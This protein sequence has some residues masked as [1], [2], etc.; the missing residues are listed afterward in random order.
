MSA[1]ATPAARKLL[2]ALHGQTITTATGRQNTILALNDDHVL[3]GTKRSPNGTAISIAWVQDALDRL[4]TDGEVEINVASV[5]HRSA[6]VGAVLLTLPGASIAATSPPRIRL[7]SGTARQQTIEIEGLNHWWHDL[8]DERYWLE[9]TD[10][11]D[12][13]VDLHAPQRDA[14][15]SKTPGY[16]LIWLVRPG[17]TVFHYDRKGK[18]IH[19][20]SRAVGEVAEDPVI[21]LSHRAATRRR[22]HDASPTGLV[23]RPRGPVSAPGCD[24]P[25]RPPR[26]I[27]SCPL[28][29][30]RPPRRTSRCS[31]LPFLVL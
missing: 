4:S 16:S 9:I 1:G 12:I 18:A 28:R 21:W 31:L 30:R 14:S 13:G 25:Q 24:Q 22:L 29:P 3:V 17:D 15:G 19:F 23:A 5:G 20:W 27:R 2:Q 11:P 10:R 7:A 6:F 8:P 26:P